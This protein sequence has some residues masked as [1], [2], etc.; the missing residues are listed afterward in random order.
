LVHV[1][2]DPVAEAADEA[3][4]SIQDA[5]MLL[6]LVSRVIHRM[7]RSQNCSEAN[8]IL[9]HETSINFWLSLM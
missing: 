5:A 2:E 7:L 8:E 4:A 6:L 3:Q 9:D 1:I